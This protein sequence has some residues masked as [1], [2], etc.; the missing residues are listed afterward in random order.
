M[1]SIR[2]RSQ[3]GKI[4]NDE[5]VKARLGYLEEVKNDRKR[6][7]N[8]LKEVVA[9][10]KQLCAAQIGAVVLQ[11]VI[12]APKEAIDKWCDTTL[13]KIEEADADEDI[14]D[15]TNMNTEH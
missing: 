3:N 1:K 11:N 12:H 14:M 8:F 7:L 9:G 6:F 10:L 4:E 13:I 5:Q 2:A 15:D